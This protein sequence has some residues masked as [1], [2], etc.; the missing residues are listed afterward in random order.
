MARW[1]N[2]FRQDC[3]RTISGHEMQLVS[4]VFLL[5]FLSPVSAFTPSRLGI[6]RSASVAA[7][8][9]F[10]LSR[11]SARSSASTMSRTTDS[12]D[13]QSTAYDKL[14]LKLKTITQLKRAK[15]VLEYDQLVFMGQAEATAKE[16][17]AQLSA[18]AELIHEKETDPILGELLK[19][20]QQ[21]PLE[22]PDQKRLLE[23]TQKDFEQNARISPEL[24]GKMASL[25][26]E[27]YGKWVEA[28]AKDD[29]EL[30]APTLK[31]CFETAKQVALAKSNGQCSLYSQMLDDFETG[32]SSK[33]INELFDEIQEA[34]VP[35][36]VRVLKSDYQ[37]SKAPLD[38]TF[39]ITAQKKVGDEI[40]K[41]IGF[42]SNLGR[43][44]VSV[45]PFTTSFSPSDVRITSRF[46][47]TEWYQGLA[48]LIHESGHAIYE[49]NLKS[50]ALSIDS[51]LSMGT[52]ESQSLFWE[53]HV[54]LSKSFWKFATP[55][56]QQEFENFH[57]TPQEIYEA[58]NAVMPSLI[59]VEADE[60]TYPLH[61][62]LRFRIE[63]KVIEG[64]LDVNDIPQVWNKEMKSLLNVEVPSDA[65][66]CL[67]DVHWSAFAF[68]YFP[69]YLIGAA[70]AAQL[71]Y[72][73]RK[74]FPD[75]DKL[76]EKGEFQ[77]IK[78]WLTD[79]IH[80]HGKRYPSL[81]AMLEDQLG[82]SLNPKYFI[83]YL[84]EK[85][86]DLYKLK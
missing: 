43:V 17:G 71:E 26:A 22:D 48:A 82:E 23:L 56:L 15:S 29:Y 30:F 21:E 3:S 66:G 19:Q 25:K 75:F 45:H 73:C 40:V 5:Y 31:E 44:D 59:R 14:T 46:K 37:P 50:S 54:G 80:R 74:E 10:A 65:K 86:T 68:G 53:R 12:C 27:A 35:L 51:A 79:K 38:G 52:H 32:M 55:L 70:T 6:L 39:D 4:V 83:D 42:N 76:I 7:S 18:L 77:D 9:R 24:A 85:Y 78:E 67:Q 60:L 28:R 72:Y 84:T 34:L 81:D 20:A 11:S 64:D 33:R 36:I 2:N 57:Y 41:K 61:V 69:T 8:F 47:E 13:T 49:Q 63:S 1:G 58:V 62:I 16:R